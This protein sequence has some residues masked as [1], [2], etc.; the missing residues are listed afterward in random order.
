MRG[1][2]HVELASL[3]SR[4]AEL[5]RHKK[6]VNGK[7]DEARQ[8]LA[9]L[10]DEERA[11]ASA[12]GDAGDRASR[13]SARDLPTRRRRPA[14]SPAPNSRAAAAVSYAYGKLG[15][16]Y[17]WGATGPDAFDCSGLIPGRVPRRGHRTAPHDL[18]PDQRRPPRLTLRTAPR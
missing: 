15:S 2:A 9:R 18:R 17:V 11:P 12:T 7:L 5:K 16:P 10:S 13:S 8:L 14:P 6:T 1:A 4:Q 3:K